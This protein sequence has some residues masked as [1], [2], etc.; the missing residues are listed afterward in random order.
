MSL[1]S[2]FAKV[3][4]DAQA[5]GAETF[6]RGGR[7]DVAVTIGANAV[8]LAASFTTGVLL[9]HALGPSGRGA[10]AAIITAPVVVAWLFALGSIQTVSYFQAKAPEGARLLG[11]WLALALPLGVAGALVGEALLPIVFSAQSDETLRLGREVMPVAV[12]L[13]LNEALTGMVVGDRRFLFVNLVRAGSQVSLAILYAA[14]ILAGDLTVD[15]AVAT[16][17]VVQGASTVL[18]ISACAARHG[19]GK[20]SR[21][22][23]RSA[24]LYGLKGHGT[25]VGAFTNARLDLLI[26]PAFLPA[27]SVGLYSVATG[28]SWIVVVLSGPIAA[29]ALPL[30]ARSEAGGSE[31]IWRLLR[32]TAI[33]AGLVAVVLVATAPQLLRIVYGGEFVG[34]ADSLRILLPGSVLFASALI[35]VSG[36]FSK[37]RPFSATAAQGAGALVTVVGLGLFLGSGG[38]LAAAIVSSIAYTVV[39]VIALLLYRRAV[40][41]SPLEA[42]TTT[43]EAWE[44]EEAVAAA[45]VAVSETTPRDLGA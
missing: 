20:P 21:S 30:A 40:M 41:R 27:S 45:T 39:F 28:V 17:V 29:M 2:G 34:A 16:F 14:L 33:T 25:N 22:L 37:N 4:R 42:E 43:H 11:T 18:L 44:P 24:T 35:L 23:A 31:V 26:M 7:E 5:R 1:R 38:I 9:A 12:I 13:V 19:I 36:L 3:L 8:V 15:T 10:T 6:G 32:V